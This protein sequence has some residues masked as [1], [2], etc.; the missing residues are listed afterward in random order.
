MF[1]D[2]TVTFFSVPNLINLVKSANTELEKNK[3]LV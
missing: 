1:A 3:H 2:L